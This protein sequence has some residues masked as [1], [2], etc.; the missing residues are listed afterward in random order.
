MAN[1]NDH[2]VLFIAA[3]RF[4]ELRTLLEKEYGFKILEC[5]MPPFV[6]FTSRK[7]VIDT[8]EGTFFL[9]EKP[10]Y[11]SSILQLKQSGDFQSYMASKVTFVPPIILTKRGEKFVHWNGRAYFLAEFREGRIYN[12]STQDLKEMLRAIDS[13]TQFAE[14]FTEQNT[15][16]YEKTDSDEVLKLIELLLKEIKTKEDGV[17]FEDVQKLV[18]DLRNEYRSYAEISFLVSHGDL[19]IFNM[20]F[21]NGEV[22]AL[23]DFDNV[24]R[25]PRFHDLA[26]FLVSATLINYIAPLTNLAHPLF[27]KPDTQ[28][29]GI[30]LKNYRQ[31]YLSS[32]KDE[33]FFF[34]LVKIVWLEILILA[35]LKGDY[36]LQELKDA[37]VTI[38]SKE[39][40]AVMMKESNHMKIFIWDFHDTLE[41]GTLD[42][43]TEIANT[44]LE[45]NGS[46]K[47][48]SVEKMAALPSFSWETF[49]ASHLP[50]LSPEQIKNVAS[51]AYDT[52]KFGHLGLKYSR[53]RFGAKELLQEI[54]SLG[55]IN[56][57][58]SNSRPDNLTTYI[59]QVGLGDFI[60]S[61]IGVDDGKIASKSDVI[62]RKV[63]AANQ[64]LASYMPDSVYSVGDSESDLQMAR[65]IGADRFFWIGSES[66]TTLHQEKYK[67]IANDTITFIH[68]LEPIREVLSQE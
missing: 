2:D 29:S 57:V 59:E 12:G 62:K 19:A 35:V 48:Y 20:I 60:D 45:R 9:K 8:S 67:D 21:E 66:S 25:L 39:F 34:V 40:K 3:D 42:V 17:V 54:K 30:I 44:L 68:N 22:A 5:S 27:V 38:Q 53:P 16:L 41:V 37:I 14:E 56:V 18:E 47:R 33:E 13:F 65:A 15:D 7:A 28:K 11:C 10:K 46:S 24:A 52:N 61:Y 58:I 23:N 50:D 1:L 63:A 64:I 31:R 43:I 6:S 51:S 4:S 49:F 26:E 32:E 36:L 55:H